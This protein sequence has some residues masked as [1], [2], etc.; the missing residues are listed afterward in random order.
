MNSPLVDE[1]TDLSFL[2]MLP[3]GG[4]GMTRD[5]DEKAR[6]FFEDHG[7]EDC[8]AQGCGFTESAGAFCYGLG[9][10]NLPGY[11]GIPLAGN[12]SAVFDSNTGEE[13]SYNEIEQIYQH[14]NK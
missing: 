10:K 3:C 9:D 8:F 6:K 7:A 4:D 5:S 1:T 13:L 12:I 14:I 2:E 11:M